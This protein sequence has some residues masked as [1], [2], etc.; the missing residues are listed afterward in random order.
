ME[1]IRLIKKQE[2]KIIINKRQ[3]KIRLFVF[4]IIFLITY[5]SGEILVRMISP[6]ELY[7]KHNPSYPTYPKEVEYDRDLGWSTV[8]NYKT[9]PYTRQGRRPIVTITHNSKGYRMDHEV[10]ETKPKI[11]ITGDS[12][13]YGFWVD[14]KKVVSA[15][16]SKMLGDK[17]EVIN[18]GVGGY[19]T[20]QA[21]LRFLRDGLPYRPKVVVHALFTND[22]SNIV[23]NYQYNVFKPMFVIDNGTLKLTNYPVPVS[24][25]MERSYPKVREHPIKGFERLMQSWSHLYVLYKNK[26]PIIKS[27]IEYAFKTPQK[28]DYFNSYKDGEFWVIERDYTNITKYS[29]YL[30]S[31]IL[32]AYNQLAKENNITFILVVIG[33]RISVDSEMQKATVKNYYNIDEDFFD[34]DKIYNLLDRFAEDNDIRIINLY[35]LF[36][37]EFREN[38]R[39]MYLDGDHHLN[40][41][42]HE[43]FAKEVY[44]YLVKEGLSQN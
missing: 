19:G 37:K 30:N 25:D 20:D 14:D 17:Y 15:K 12:L 35:P 43:L 8:K 44:D 7:N 27:K 42:G 6:Q 29:F 33:D 22:F 39:N 18:L 16:L 10:N 21:F 24:K 31:Q 1:E 36:K 34:Y 2:G 11:I 4:L 13:S 23:A 28:I 5:A 38:K 3:L 41:Y 9:Q 32:K 26:I 40:D